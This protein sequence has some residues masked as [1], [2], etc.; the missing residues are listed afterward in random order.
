MKSIIGQCCL[1]CW[2]NARKKGGT[3]GKSGGCN[4]RGGEKCEK[5]RETCEKHENQQ[6]K[7]MKSMKIYENP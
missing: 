5:K 2:Q 1:E 3:D 4:P 7:M 6:K